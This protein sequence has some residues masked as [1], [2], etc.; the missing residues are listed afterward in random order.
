MN[1]EILFSERQ[2]FN[3]IGSWL[4]LLIAF[5][6]LHFVENMPLTYLVSNTSILLILVLLLLSIAVW[7]LKLEKMEF[8]I[9]FSR[10]N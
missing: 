7:I 4:F 6:I 1:N 8:I 10:F 3:I 2:R 9:N 5:G